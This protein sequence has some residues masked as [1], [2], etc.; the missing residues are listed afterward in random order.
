MPL[1]M[2]VSLVILSFSFSSNFDHQ[3]YIHSLENSSYDQF[4]PLFYFTMWAY[5]MSSLDTRF[6]LFTLFWVVFLI[7]AKWG[8]RLF[9]STSLVYLAPV[10]VV[11]VRYFLAAMLIAVVI[12]GRSRLAGLL[13]MLMHYAAVLPV[14]A[15]W[16][17]IFST[18]VAVALFVIGYRSAPSEVLALVTMLGGIDYSRYLELSHSSNFDY[19]SFAKYA[20][21]P[22]VLVIVFILSGWRREHG[23][24]LA[25]FI[26]ALG[27]KIGIDGIEVISR[28]SSI[29]MVIGIY[30]ALSIGNIYARWLVVMYL[31]S[32]ALV[33]GFTGWQ[34]HLQVYS[35]SDSIFGSFIK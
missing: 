6:F 8:D 28:I 2:I 7:A 30:Y 27:L 10:G 23:R 20:V 11:S 24:I 9:L 3:T 14:A 13:S 31:S 21:L 35:E 34:E 15:I 18:T 1:G 17:G 29:L 4:E 26:L 25:I 12:N 22:I 32:H 19:G 16:I 33:F 5:G